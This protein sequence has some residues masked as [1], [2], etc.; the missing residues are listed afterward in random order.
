MFGATS[1]FIPKYKNE[2]FGI[3]NIKILSIPKLFENFTWWN[4][5]NLASKAQ[6]TQRKS[7]LKELNL[8]SLTKMLLLELKLWIYDSW[9][10]SLISINQSKEIPSITNLHQRKKSWSFWDSNLENDYSS[11]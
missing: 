2:N 6:I 11:Y 1:S 8:Y 4:T 3:F 7:I 9:E 5:G 10:G